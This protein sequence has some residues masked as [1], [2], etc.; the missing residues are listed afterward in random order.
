MVNEKININNGF[1]ILVKYICLIILFAA[2]LAILLNKKDGILYYFIPSLNLFFKIIIILCLYI[3]LITFSIRIHKKSKNSFILFLVI[4]SG[5]SCFIWN[6]FAGTI[7]I[8]DYKVL[9]EGASDIANGIFK[10]GY[11]KTSYYYFYNHQI[12]YASYLSI[13]VKLLGQ[14]I[15]WLKLLDCT[16]IIGTVLMIYIIA[17]K[18]FNENTAVISSVLYSTFLFNLFGSSIINNQH[19]SALLLMLGL[20]LFMNTT[21]NKYAAITGIVFGIMNVIRPFAIIIIIAVSIYSLY[22]IFMKTNQKK[23]LIKLGIIL[24]SYFI[25]IWVCNIILISAHLT[26][27]PISKSNIPYFKF[28]IGLGAKDRSIYGTTGKTTR[29]S[30]VYTDLE[31]VGFDYD[32]YNNDSKRF[33][34]QSILNYKSTIPYLKKKMTAFLGEKDNQIIFALD[35]IKM[36][37]KYIVS[38]YKLS[39]LQYF[40]F[41]LFAIMSIIFKRNTIKNEGFLL[42]LLIIG[43]VLVH[44]PI[45]T[46]TRYRY[47]IY[48]FIIIM[49]GD[50]ID[51]I[52]CRFPKLRINVSAIKS[53]Y[54]A[55]TEHMFDIL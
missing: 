14:N 39:H 30:S 2:A 18:K 7:Q 45:E 52:I 43:F 23:W 29:M 41:V 12:G 24:L 16:Y 22:M 40:L 17:I 47:E 31:E 50:A 4:I 46:Q 1:I 9:L 48:I 33:V 54:Y 15:F 10:E 37:S 20:Y 8:S 6:Y 32:K 5:F 36:N 51:Q 35:N 11:D 25:T 27:Y 44:I 42:Y 55:R 34:I 3:F 19:L 53:F 38:L 13:I 26:P 28:V 49:S 21:K